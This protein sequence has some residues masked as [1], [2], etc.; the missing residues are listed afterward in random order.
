LANSIKDIIAEIFDE[1]LD[2]TS[3]QNGITCLIILYGFLKIENINEYNRNKILKWV[4]DITN[5]NSME[6]SMELC[7]M[8]ASIKKRLIKL[9]FSLL[10]DIQ[11]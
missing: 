11:N 7:N 8:I 6:L 10:K 3:K 2:E 1:D 9:G 4:F 5:I